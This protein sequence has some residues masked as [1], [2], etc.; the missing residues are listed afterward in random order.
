M[1]KLLLSFALCLTL[2]LAGICCLIPT[3]G[4]DSPAAAVSAAGL[5][6][7]WEHVTPPGDSVGDGSE[8]NPW[9]IYTA[10]DLTHATRGLP[11]SATVGNRGKHWIL[12][13]DI[14]LTGT[15]APKILPPYA[16]FDGNNYIIYNLTI[17]GSGNDRAFFSDM[18]GTIKNITFANPSVTASAARAAVVTASVWRNPPA[19]WNTAPF[20]GLGRIANFQR[21]F[22]GTSS[23]SG[24]VIGV[25]EAAGLIGEVAADGIAIV[26]NCINWA[27]VTS[28]SDGHLGGIIG[29]V[30]DRAK[31]TIMRSGNEG[32]IT[33][34][35]DFYPNQTYTARAR[36]VGGLIGCIC[37]GDAATVE[38]SYN[39]G[40]VKG[41]GGLVGT[42]L[43]S[44]KEL[45]IRNCFNDSLFTPALNN[46]YYAG[47]AVRQYTSVAIRAENNWINSDKFFLN[48]NKFFINGGG[49]AASGTTSPTNTEYLPGGHSN[50]WFTSTGASAPSSP[51]GFNINAGYS[52]SGNDL[53]A[54]VQQL[55]QGIEHNPAFMIINGKVELV[56]A[57]KDTRIVYF[58]TNGAPVMPY[59]IF[60]DPTLPT[61][62]AFP[63]MGGLNG[64]G[65]RPWHEFGGWKL[66]GDISGTIYDADGDDFTSM[67]MFN[68]PVG[69]R[70]FTFEAQWDPIKIYVENMP[71]TLQKADGTPLPYFTIGQDDVC[72][73]SSAAAANAYWLIKLVGSSD[74]DTLG[75]DDGNPFDFS[76]WITEDSGGIG[77]KYLDDHVEYNGG[78]YKHFVTVDRIVEDY[79][80]TFVQVSVTVNT[81]IGGSLKVSTGASNNP[82]ISWP[83]QSSFTRGV[84]KNQPIWFHIEANTYYEIEGIKINGAA[85]IPS[86]DPQ[87]YSFSI[88]GSAVDFA[89]QILFKRAKYD[90][91]IELILV[92]ESSAFSLYTLPEGLLTSG[93][94]KISNPNKYFEVEIASGAS[95]S[96]ALGLK[97]VQSF[98]DA[99]IANQKFQFIG[100]KIWE[101]TTDIIGAYTILSDESTFTL[102]AVMNG[103]WLAEYLKNGNEVSIIAEYA[104]VYSFYVD[105][106]DNADFDI[107]PSD[108][109][110]KAYGVTYQL[111]HDANPLELGYN[112]APEGSVLSI[113][114][115]MSLFADERHPSFL[116]EFDG[117]EGLEPGEEWL[118]EGNTI[119][120][121][122]II[123]DNRSNPITETIRPVFTR[124]SFG[125][126]LR[127]VSLSSGGTETEERGVT[128]NF[129]KNGGVGDENELQLGDRITALR[130]PINLPGYRF[131]NKF[132]VTHQCSDCGAANSPVYE[133]TVAN[134][135]SGT[136]TKIDGIIDNEII[137][138]EDFL[139]CHT[140]RGSMITISAHY[141][142]LFTLGV[143]I[144]HVGF[145]ETQTAAASSI[146]V[147][148][149]NV[150]R[151]TELTGSNLISELKNLERNEILTLV[152]VPN[153]GFEF[154]NFTFSGT[155]NILETNSA[156][157]L[158]V[159]MGHPDIQAHFRPAPI[160]INEK[161]IHNIFGSVVSA[162]V[163]TGTDAQNLYRAEE[164]TDGNEKLSLRT[165]DKIELIS[166]PGFLGTFGSKINNWTINRL[167]F[168]EIEKTYGN[169]SQVGNIVTIALTPDWLEKYG[170]Q[171]DYRVN[172]GITTEFWLFIV[173][174]VSLV[175]LLGLAFLIY[176]L[177]L[178][179]KKRI[180][181]EFLLADKRAR[182][183][184]TQHNIISDVREGKAVGGVSDETVRKAMETER[185]KKKDK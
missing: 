136:I 66:V 171:L 77:A 140:S 76:S 162:R 148:H 137:I 55:N 102:N 106:Y 139:F 84:E 111:T 133:I 15:W 126:T 121:T 83:L 141:T 164:E 185:D 89:V 90:V 37:G 41:H 35:G 182:A 180:I 43:N 99:S 101:N 51:N 59:H 97:A 75:E 130:A 18:M 184:F 110:D 53:V 151:G 22:V 34:N 86:G 29:Q 30:N 175:L 82:A 87:E 17:T 85:T 134:G 105:T 16:V 124:K 145:P 174:P 116:Y 96:T 113:T 98:T 78:T 127:A 68:F 25:S 23:Q 44:G 71:A 166:T 20:T 176:Y 24:S 72:F 48:T 112:E 63:K 4:N 50:G 40:D 107:F 170:S 61:F 19:N 119:I 54:F 125:V 67:T 123:M 27:S 65:Q 12:M 108:A 5:F 122:I 74:Y 60:I 169:V 103:D 158:E 8:G 47:I 14:I 42:V 32:A 26:E 11:S 152:P 159:T 183:G 157:N 156:G 181:K 129:S 69:E 49:I 64:I 132:T 154:V 161:L 3:K 93:M 62:N 117:F 38:Y 165:G 31:A 21:V 92:T 28:A 100:W 118:Q 39:R 120:S 104:P 9:K 142:R 13:D 79:S 167:D 1:K 149:I 46:L 52:G 95:D 88:P 109:S 115:C 177:N 155:S 168:D 114:V 56:A 146:A 2:M 10:A 147:G 33:T 138:D 172:F 178:Q 144:R 179:R 45:A 128:V 143:N 153:F 7:P 36:G 6:D 160:S 70:T 57:N 173:L 135:T 150:Y 94:T 163:W 58:D 80:S 73:K 81:P 91:N 131:D